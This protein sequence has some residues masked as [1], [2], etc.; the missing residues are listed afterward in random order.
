MI[1]KIQGS[2]SP[3]QNPH[4]KKVEQFQESVKL[5]QQA[6]NEHHKTPIADMQK[7]QRFE[8]IMRKSMQVM[9][10]TAKEACRSQGA[11]CQ[12]MEKAEQKLETD[13]QS[14]HKSVEDKDIAKSDQVYE[15]LQK[16]VKNLEG[17]FTKE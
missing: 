9:S 3:E 5:F 2:N 11:K 6:L 8:D 13:F 17:F 1:E 14:F 10:E 4:T 7:R 12:E 16:D 15:E